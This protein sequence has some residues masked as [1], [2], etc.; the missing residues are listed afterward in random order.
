MTREQIEADWATARTALER[1]AKL[2]VSHRGRDEAAR[3]ALIEAQQALDRLYM[4]ALKA[5]FKDAQESLVGRKAMIDDMVV[6]IRQY[7]EP[8]FLVRFPSHAMM[9][10]RRPDFELLEDDHADKG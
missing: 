3:D 2:H 8:E 9:W 6:E 10:K 5:T 4:E 7:Q 1:C